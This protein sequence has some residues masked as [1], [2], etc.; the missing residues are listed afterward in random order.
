MKNFG[1]HVEINK[2]RKLRRIQ[3]WKNE[4]LKITIQATN[5]KL[6]KDK[7]KKIAT[8]TKNTGSKIIA[9]D[10]LGKDKKKKKAT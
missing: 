1:Q 6:G 3:S 7:K 4:V 9:D 8:Q 10:K 5:N 2:W